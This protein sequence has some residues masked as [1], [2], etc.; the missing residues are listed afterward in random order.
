MCHI[1][2]KMKGFCLL[3]EITEATV[4]NVRRRSSASAETQIEENTEPK[5]GKSMREN[6][7]RYHRALYSCYGGI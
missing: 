6:K 5:K 2:I 7:K 4:L 3:S 1:K